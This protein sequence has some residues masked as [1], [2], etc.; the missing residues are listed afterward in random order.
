MWLAPAVLM[1][2]PKRFG[3]NPE[4]ATT[5]VFAQDGASGP[6]DSGRTGVAAVAD[7]A[8]LEVER[9]AEAVRAAGVQVFLAEDSPDP[10]KPDACFP[11]NWVSFHPDGTAVL[12]PMAVA[13][14]RAERRRELLQ[15]VQAFHGTRRVMDLSPLEADGAY[16]EGTGSLILDHAARIAYAAHSP[17]TTP[18]GLK[19][20]SEAIGYRIVAFDAEL[21]GAPVYHTNVMMALGPDLVVFAPDLVP[22]G[23]PRSALLTALGGRRR[24]VLESS[25]V[26][27]YAANLLYLR[28]TSGPVAV[29]SRRAFHALTVAQRGVLGR[30]VVVDIDTVETIGGGSARCL[31]AE[32]FGVDSPHP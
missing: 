9:A 10:P 19:A 11:N 27:E 4:A 21:D 17:R 24:V 25:Q 18:A 30:T 20:F 23:E 8:R 15:Q 5:N 2:C 12:Y 16:L 32:V 6:E 3:F 13:S 22:S 26:R 7:R 14:R 28:S 31:L 1:V 29:L